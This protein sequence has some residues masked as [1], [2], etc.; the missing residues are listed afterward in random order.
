LIFPRFA[1]IPVMS[2]KKQAS[3]SRVAERIDLLPLVRVIGPLW[4]LAVSVLEMELRDQT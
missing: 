1:S 3:I 4:I 2:I